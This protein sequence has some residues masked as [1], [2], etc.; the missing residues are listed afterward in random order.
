M[1]A[2]DTV[3]ENITVAWAFDQDV[4]NSSVK[5]DETGNYDIDVVAGDVDLYVYTNDSFT[6][7][8]FGKVI[9]DISVGDYEEHTLDV[10]LYLFQPCQ[11]ITNI[12]PV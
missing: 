11:L 3:I 8:Y 10:Y 5:S 2:D 4:S 1:L 9:E 7:G 12:F 6:P